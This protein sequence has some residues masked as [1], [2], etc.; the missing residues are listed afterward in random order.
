MAASAALR[1][2]FAE[3]LAERRKQP[4]D[5]LISDLASVEVDGSRLT[6]DEIFAFLLLLLPAGVETTYRYSGNL[7]V[8]LLTAPDAL[9]EVRADLSL[10]PQAIE[11]ALRW[12]PPITT[13]VRRAARDTELAGVEIPAGTSVGISIAAANRDPQRYADPDRFDLR[14]SDSSHLTFGHGPHICL[15]MHLARMESA[16]ALGT[17]LERLPDL[18]LAPDAPPPTVTGVAFRSPG[19]LPVAFTAR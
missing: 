4:A 1:D 15:G 9:E 11:E 17:L 6:D 16:V 2:Y 19:G 14:R 10:L 18:R 8:A 3:I 12:E 5:D 13:L 7:L